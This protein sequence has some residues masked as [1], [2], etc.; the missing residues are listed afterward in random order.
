[1]SQPRTHPH[2]AFWEA[3]TIVTILLLILLFSVLRLNGYL[4]G[5]DAGEDDN[6]QQERK[7]KVVQ[8]GGEPKK[9]ATSTPGPGTPGGDGSRSGGRGEVTG[10][11]GG[12]DQIKLKFGDKNKNTVQFLLP[13]KSKHEHVQVTIEEEIPRDFTVYRARFDP[14]YDDII[15]VAPVKPG[16]PVSALNPKPLS[17]LKVSIEPP[18]PLLMGVVGSPTPYF[19]ITGV[20]VQI[21]SEKPLEIALSGKSVPIPARTGANVEVLSTIGSR[22][23]LSP[24]KVRP[25]MIVSGLRY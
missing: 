25:L 23:P 20:P 1:M 6:G 24:P 9:P 22:T 11:G 19:N 3:V 17:P 12:D 15:P 13:Q 21:G 2:K 5:G 18:S 14:H 4:G 8:R 16:G 10:G 7:K